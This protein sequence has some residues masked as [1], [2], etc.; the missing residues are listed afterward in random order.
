MKI[1][2]ASSWRNEFQP[3]VVSA[4]LLDGHDVYDFRID[5][6]SWSQVDSDWQSWTSS[7]Y[8]NLMLDAK[9]GNN[10]IIRRRFDRDMKALMSCDICVLVLPSG[11]SAH[12][13]AGYAVGAGKLLIVLL[14]GELEPDLMYL[15]SSYP[16][17]LSIDEVIRFIHEDTMS[18]R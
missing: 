15:M 7:K 12:L 8:R 16:I 14:L 1:Y 9:Q 18:S 4:L 17:A 5:G 2:V 10:D 6:F 3:S 13:E 11:R